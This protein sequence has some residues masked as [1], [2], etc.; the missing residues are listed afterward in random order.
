[1]VLPFVSISVLEFIELQVGERCQ[2]ALQKNWL[3]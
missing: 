3:F 1:M 2:G